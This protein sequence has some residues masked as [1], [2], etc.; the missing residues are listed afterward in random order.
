M[1]RNAPVSPHPLQW[2]SGFLSFISVWVS[3]LVEV[4][5]S[6]GKNARDTG[7]VSACDVRLLCAQLIMPA[8]TALNKAKPTGKDTR[9]FARVSSG[10][11]RLLEEAAAL[12]GQSVGAF[13]IAQAR[14]AASGLLEEHSIIRLSVEESRRLKKAL[15]SPPPKPRA[16]MKRAL[17]L[18]RETVI[19]DVNPE[20]GKAQRPASSG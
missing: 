7:T 6:V 14:T 20:S 5:Q 4:Q 10:D 3:I 16:A 9:F 19:S 15:F 2:K 12:T 13:V 18:Y 11:K 17:K 8:T 1:G